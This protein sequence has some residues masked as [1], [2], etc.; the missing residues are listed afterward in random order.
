VSN[1]A[2]PERKLAG[3][4]ASGRAAVIFLNAGFCEDQQLL[5][6]LRV[7]TGA[8]ATTMFN[9]NIE[10]DIVATGYQH[11]SALARSPFVSWIE[12]P[13]IRDPRGNLSFIEGLRH[14]PFPIRRVF[15]LYDVPAGE[16][17]EGHAYMN[18][19][20][21]II[22]ASGSFTVT[23]DNGKCREQFFLNRPHCGLYIPRMIW[24]EI[25]NFSSGSI[26]LVLASEEYDEHDYYRDYD[27]FCSALSKER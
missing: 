3:W 9:L 27:S 13:Q 8:R 14:L 7:H 19:Q 11:E 5:Q 15:Y 18:L 1:L 20:Q 25:E 6:N 23:V 10:N 17:R 16:T 2:E 4:R 22:A 12:F 26:C 21:C 24:R